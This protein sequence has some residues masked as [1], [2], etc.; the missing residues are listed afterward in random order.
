M[1]GKGLAD[2][3]KSK[4]GVAYVYAFKMA[5][6][7]L[8]LINQFAGM[9][10]S[11][12]TPSYIEKAKKK[13]GQVAVDCSGLISAY[14]MKILGSAQLYAQAYTRL[15]IANVKDFAV[16]TVLWKNGHV[17]VYIG[18]ENGIPMCV[19]AK[20]INYGVVKTRVSDTAWKYGL[21]FSW[22]T[23]DYT[24]NLVNTATWKGTNPYKEPTKLICT[25][26]IAKAK[27]YS[28][29]KWTNKGDDVRWAQWE[30]KEAGYDI[31]TTGPNKDGIDGVWGSKCDVAAE[32]FQRSCKITAD[33]I[34]G[35]TTRKYLKNK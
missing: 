11:V 24:V 2:F 19:E 12:Y 30:L 29:D 15:P 3:A 8:A 17:G 6:V 14:T 25:A 4:L 20:G 34:V 32:E 28:D 27:R 18:M 1:N 7:T 22:M 35:V 21:T 33:K 23:Y 5:M 16:G 26:A 9:Y 13:I 10:P 31:G